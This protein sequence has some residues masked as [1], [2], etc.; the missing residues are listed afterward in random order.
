MKPKVAIV[1]PDGGSVHGEF[2]RDLAHLVKY[3]MS[4]PGDYEIIGPEPVHGPYLPHNRNE[5]IK[6]AK[7]ENADWLFHLECDH[8][9]EPTMLRQ[10]MQTANKE[11]KPIV[12]GL[13]S[14]GIQTN[15]GTS[16][17]VCDC[18]FADEPSG[19]Y[20][21]MTTPSDFRPFQVDAAGVGV[22]LCHMSVF[23]VIPY[24]WFWLEHTQLLT[25]D[26]E[27]AKINIMG[28]DF[29]FYRKA[30]ELGYAVWCDPRPDIKHWKVMPLT[31]SSL[32]R[33]LERAQEVQ[34]ELGRM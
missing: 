34:R 31:P 7:R 20:R 27:E 26:G 3:E 2:A 33:F 19:G 29:A 4:D 6:W 8:G 11:E 15:N 22:L 23:D 30:R 9:F 10:L 21:P 28:D 12:V 25:N 1:W 14:I 13:Y 32:R 5:L 16:V 17:E 18:I 24:P